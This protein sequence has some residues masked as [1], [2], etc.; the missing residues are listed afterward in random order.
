[1]ECRILTGA[2]MADLRDANPGAVVLLEGPHEYKGVE[3]FA[4]TWDLDSA[5]KYRYP[6]VRGLHFYPARSDWT[7]TWD[8]AVL[9][10]R[11]PG[12]VNRIETTEV[13]VW[14]RG[15]NSAIQAVPPLTK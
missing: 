8:G 10:Q 15:S 6:D 4:S 11:N 14:R 9:E 5:M 13:W 1:M 12:L 3:V 2:P 7:T